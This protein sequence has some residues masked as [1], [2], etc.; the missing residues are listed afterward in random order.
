MNFLKNAALWILA[1]LDE[2]STWAGISAAAGAISTTL[3]SHA[4]LGVAIVAG[5]IAA[6]KAE[7]S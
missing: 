4:G 5:A 3:Q 6:A 7:K 2:P 1:R